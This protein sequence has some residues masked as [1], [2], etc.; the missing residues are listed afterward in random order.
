MAKRIWHIYRVKPQRLG[1]WIEIINETPGIPEHIEFWCGWD[2]FPMI[3]AS[4][5]WADEMRRR[6]EWERDQAQDPLP[7]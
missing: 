1:M 7:F 2:D 6:V 5:L 4:G 3:E